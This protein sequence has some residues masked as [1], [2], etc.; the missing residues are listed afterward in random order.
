MPELWDLARYVEE[1]PDDREQRWRLAKKLYN[2]WEYRLALEHLQILRGEF[3]ERVNIA[4]YLAATYYRLG[5]YGE[6]RRELE[7]AIATWPHEVGL[8]EQLGRVLEVAGER[9]E[10]IQVW[11]DVRALDAHHPIA[12]SA[13][14]RLKAE[15]DESPEGELHLGSSDSGMNLLPGRVCQQCGAQ[16]GEDL[17]VCW[18]CGAPLFSVRPRARGGAQPTPTGQTRVPPEQ[19]NL[20]A[21]L[22]SVGLAAGTVYGV[23]DYWLN[24]W[25]AEGYIATVGDLYWEG[26]FW[27][28]VALTALIFILWPV[29]IGV[30]LQAV[31]RSV[32]PPS[33]PA[34][35]G[36]VLG[37]IVALSA[38]LPSGPVLYTLGGTLLISFVLI[39]STYRLGW[40]RGIT[41]WAVHAVVLLGTLGLGV[42]A[43]ESWQLDRPLNPL[44]EV[45]AITSFT[46]NNA[47]D[48]TPVRTYEAPRFPFEHTVTVR[49]TGSEW[50]HARASEIAVRVSLVGAA[51]GARY[52]LINEDGTTAFFQRLDRTA[53]DTMVRLVPG[54]T[55]RAVLTAP[56]A[57]RAAIVY[58]G[59]LVLADTV[60][61]ATE[62]A[63]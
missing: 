57:E 20:V 25:Q 4:R 37:G 42:W 52:E 24:H 56:Q 7:R 1:H 23:L 11:E 21:G 15:T 51:R 40:K 27:T 14:R 8:R 31:N 58:A 62:S 19:L 29:A 10:A 38:W 50:I 47:H 12:D 54:T 26:F 41:A 53:L 9:K 18:Q 22:V 33:V 2:A 17:E 44:T 35:T 48:Q 49:D 34:L 63:P 28:R 32:K 3:S 59:V 61:P 16:N 13:I 60:A 6:A 55:Y 5:R 45:P 39:A 46:L 30:A 36:L 43:L